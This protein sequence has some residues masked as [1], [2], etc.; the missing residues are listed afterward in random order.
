MRFFSPSCKPKAAKLD[1]SALHSRAASNLLRVSIQAAARKGTRQHRHEEPRRSA[2]WRIRPSLQSSAIFT[3]KPVCRPL[4]RQKARRD[5]EDHRQNRRREEKESGKKR[6]QSRWSDERRSFRRASAEMV[7]Q[8]GE[9]SGSSSDAGSIRMRLVSP[10]RYWKSFWFPLLPQRRLELSPC[11]EWVPWNT[12]SS[13]IYGKR[14][15]G[16]RPATRSAGISSFTPA[17]RCTFMRRTSFTYLTRPR[18]EGFRRIWWLLGGEWAW[19]W[20]NS[21][22]SPMRRREVAKLS[23]RRWSGGRRR[24][25]AWVSWA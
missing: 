15:S 13:A 25:A 23:I 10:A 3:S 7:L 14:E 20:I 1:D 8:F 12:A 4:S 17:I 16:L 18:R 11:P 24:P 6:T 2:E 9:H 19:R 5:G 21:V 22:Y